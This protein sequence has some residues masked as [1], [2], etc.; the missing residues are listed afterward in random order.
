MTDAK[1]RNKIGKD[2]ICE[3]Y[4]DVD[5]FYFLIDISLL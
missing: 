3:K 4:L 5:H 1:Y 2:G